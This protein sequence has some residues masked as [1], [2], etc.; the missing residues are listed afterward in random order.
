MIKPLLIL[1]LALGS[2]D[3]SPEATGTIKGV[4]HNG[5]RS[6][7]PIADADVMLRAGQGGPLETVAVTK[8]DKIG[9]FA[10]KGIPLDP[11]IVLL[12]GAD[13]DGIH[14]PA[15]R[16]HLDRAHPDAE[17]SIRVFDAVRSPSPL[18]ALRH[19][20]D[21]TV[22]SQVM[23]IR[24]RLVVTNESR[25]TFVGE[26]VDKE[27]PVTLRLSVPPNFDHVTFGSEFY[28][29]RFRIVEHQLVTEVPWTP[30]ERELKF[31]YRIPLEGSGG[32]FR[33]PLDIPCDAVS[34]RVHGAVAK[35]V[36]CDLPV[37]R[38]S[39][40]D[41]SFVSGAKQLPAGHVIEL[42]VGTLPFPWAFYA[43]WGAVAT[44]VVLIIGTVTVNRFRSKQSS[45]PGK[46]AE[47]A[48]RSKRKRKRS[49]YAA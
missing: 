12:P 13:R 1:L 6:D 46:V 32:L 25:H 9:K 11:A 23:L 27:P 43:R 20:I 41:I 47:Q 2:T 31:T 3:D 30:G 15:R 45:T 16:I 36:R 37:A 18:K 17:A 42:Q 40:D 48:T 22:E 35:K 19:V 44:L 5:S 4:V 8:T 39:G 29:R 7:A 28:G 14:Y 49:Q 26:R 33:R 38:Q 24:E 34:V 10:F 21:V